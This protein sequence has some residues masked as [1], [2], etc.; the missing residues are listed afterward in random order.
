MTNRSYR[1]APCDVPVV[2][3]VDV[4]VTGGGFAG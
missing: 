4:L 1:I 3:E 2:L